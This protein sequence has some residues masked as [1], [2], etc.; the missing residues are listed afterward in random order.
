MAEELQ[1]LIE[2]IRKEGVETAS[3]E[4]DAIV[5]QAKDKAAKIVN[6]AETKAKSLVEKAKKDARAQ[7]E[8]VIRSLKQ[9]ARDLVITLGQ[10]CENVVTEVLE[11]ETSA[12]LSG[13]F[14]QKLLETVVSQREEDDVTVEVS[15][16]DAKKLAKFCGALAKKTG[17]EISLE[18][19]S[20]VLSGFRIGFKGQSVR[21][22]YTG[23]ALGEALSAFL[24][25]ELAKAVS[26]V[27][28]EASA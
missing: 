14:L 27:A 16:E 5:S 9:A 8:R 13:D 22:D 28:R 20:D 4:A 21:L 6:E 3:K 24:R 12:K 7:E 2:Q 15:P 1:H 17:K 10:A 26:E 19:Q 23:E 18:E 25:P 11:K